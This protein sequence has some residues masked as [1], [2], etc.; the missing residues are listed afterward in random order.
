MNLVESKSLLNLFSER[1]K[2][3]GGREGG[4]ESNLES[5]CS[6]LLEAGSLDNCFLLLVVKGVVLLDSRDTLGKII[7]VLAFEAIEYIQAMYWLKVIG[8]GWGKLFGS[9]NN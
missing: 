1:K 9:S 4:K 7:A 6:N 5:F 3:K 8:G 2:K